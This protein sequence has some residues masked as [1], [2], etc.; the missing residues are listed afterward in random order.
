[1]LR[2]NGLTRTSRLTRAAIVARHVYTGPSLKV[3]KLVRERS[4]GVCEWPGCPL[5]A[6]DYHHRLNRKMGGRYGAR[7]EQINSAAWI[8]HVCRQHHQDV[9]SAGGERLE[10]AR[11]TGWV[12]REHQ[13]ASEVPIRMDVDSYLIDDAGGRTPYP[14]EDG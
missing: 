3:R 1:M 13:M 2:R 8:V 11:D 12:L 7:R 6:T 5:V 14:E 9:T 10:L 4:G